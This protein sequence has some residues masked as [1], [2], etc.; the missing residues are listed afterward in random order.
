M[1]KVKRHLAAKILALALGVVPGMVM[2]GG[3][4]STGRNGVTMVTPS[5]WRY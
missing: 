4:C 2:A 1:R 3:G 5:V